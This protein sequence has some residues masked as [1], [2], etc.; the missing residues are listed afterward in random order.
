[1]TQLQR[2]FI[3][4]DFPE[5]VNRQ[6]LGLCTGIEKAKWIKPGQVHLTLRF[7]GDAREE[8]AGLLKLALDEVSHPGFAIT[9]KGVGTFPPEGQR[10]RPKVLW[11]GVED[12][13]PL[14]ECQR[15]IER[16]ARQAGFEP[17]ERPFH[18]HVTLAR[19]RKHPG[20]ELRK[21]LSKHRDFRAGPVRIGAVH[22]ISS[23]LTPDG[24]IHTPVQAFPL[25][26]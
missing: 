5:E 19:F 4:I 8:Q 13:A 16:A 3:A 24:A 10:V 6:L 12:P 15:K 9:L 2:L 17:E 14:I 25:T 20:E 22:L 21:W 11:V 18:P 23:T 26:E 7:I 1:M